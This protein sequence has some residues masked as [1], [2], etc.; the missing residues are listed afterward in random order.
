[1]RVYAIFVSPYLIIAEQ[2]SS[3]VTGLSSSYCHISCNTFFGMHSPNFFYTSSLGTHSFFFLGEVSNVTIF[4]FIAFIFIVFIT[5]TFHLIIVLCAIWCTHLH[6]CIKYGR[7]CELIK[8]THHQP[9]ERS[10]K[11]KWIQYVANW[12]DK[13]YHQFRVYMCMWWCIYK[14]YTIQYSNEKKNQ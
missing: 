2:C 11:I 7:V 9:T 14:R 12:T 13:M 8:C 10:T 3:A 6:D 4:T 1:M 5:R